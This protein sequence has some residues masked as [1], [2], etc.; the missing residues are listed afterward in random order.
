[1]PKPKQVAMQSQ[2][3]G[4]KPPQAHGR[5]PPHA[6]AKVDRHP[7]ESRG[8]EKE[9]HGYVGQVEVRRYPPCSGGSQGGVIEAEGHIRVVQPGAARDLE[10]RT[11]NLA[12]HPAG[13]TVV[14]AH[15][16]SIDCGS[17]SPPLPDAGK[18]R[19]IA[20]SVRVYLKDIGRAHPGDLDVAHEAALS[21]SPVRMAVHP[22]LRPA[23]VRE[24]GRG[25]V[26]RSIVDHEDRSEEHTSEL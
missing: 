15:P 2:G 13:K 11:Q 7:L 22:Q 21:V 5:V 26:R 10:R 23:Q 20:L 12:D 8:L 4:Y 18:P 6:V 9:R 25:G 16:S 3:L 19:G 24:A 14:P 1:M 17:V